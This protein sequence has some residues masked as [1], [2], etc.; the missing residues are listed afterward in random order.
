MSD[1]SKRS[2]RYRDPQ[3]RKQ[4]SVFLPATEWR[5]LRDEAART[6]L[7][8]LRQTPAADPS[9]DPRRPPDEPARRARNEE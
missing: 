2:K 7:D 5:A 3:V 4:V 6:G 8:R 9:A 1:A